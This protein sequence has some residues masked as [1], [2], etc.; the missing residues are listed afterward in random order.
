M[1]K[2][3]ILDLLDGISE[4]FVNEAAPKAAVRKNVLWARISA[5]AACFAIVCT[6]ALLIPLS[7]K[8][9]PENIPSGD[10]VSNSAEETGVKT[11]T[12][13]SSGPITEDTETVLPPET[14]TDSDHSTETESTPGTE[15]E[16]KTP[17]EPVYV[18]G[19]PVL[20][21]SSLPSGFGYEGLSVFYPWEL[22]TNNPWND[23]VSLATLP[24][25]ENY[26]VKTSQGLY[27]M[28]PIFLSEEDM[29]ERLYAAAEEYG[30]E[31]K[32]TVYHREA[33]YGG[34]DDSEF[35][36]VE[37]F[38]ICEDVILSVG[39]KGEVSCYFDYSRVRYHMSDTERAEHGAYDIKPIELG[40]LTPKSDTVTK[41]ELDLIIDLI[42]SAFPNSISTDVS[43]GYREISYAGKTGEKRM[44]PY[45]YFFDRADDVTENILNYNFRSYRI[46]FSDDM[47]KIEGFSLPSDMSLYTDKLGDYPIIT[48]DE[49]RAYLLA[50]DY[51][52]T[53]P[54]FEMVSDVISSDQVQKCELVYL[55]SHLNTCFLPYYKFHV[56]IRDLETPVLNGDGEMLKHYGVF[57]V[58][59]VREE[60]ILDYSPSIGIWQPTKNK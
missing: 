49:A 4:D 42:N 7:K 37:A 3:K 19:L 45:V 52:T 60:Y 47:S 6:A 38:G 36:T 23:N 2:D 12:D 51:L 39:S 56:R 10:V 18:N 1:K 35:G 32:C 21:Q 29:T 27:G 53:V 30:K 31:I 15:T 46:S 43:E 58:P 50:G 16:E 11:E 44:F 24:V 28:A 8:E 55:R 41:E 20:K 48:A 54:E 40:Q 33:K 59:A 14:E 22:D 25:F 9:P 26:V 5:I 17:S 34:R 57:Y 13:E